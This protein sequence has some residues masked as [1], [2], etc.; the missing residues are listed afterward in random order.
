[1]NRC[2]KCNREDKDLYYVKED[3][4]KTIQ[5]IEEAGRLEYKS[6]A[7]VTVIAVCVR[8][9]IEILSQR[10]SQNDVVAHDNINTV[11]S[12]SRSI[13]AIVGVLFLLKVVGYL[14]LLIGLSTETLWIME[15]TTWVIFI[16]FVGAIKLSQTERSQPIDQKIERVPDV[17]KKD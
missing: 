13:I 9:C 6:I 3:G 2:E 14:P 4:G 7:T 8:C 17:T 12:I 16:V 1:M 5:R 15:I 10:V 11:M